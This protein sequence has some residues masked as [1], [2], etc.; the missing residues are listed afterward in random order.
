MSPTPTDAPRGRWPAWLQPLAGQRAN[1]DPSDALTEADPFVRLW[2]GF[3]TARVMIGLTVLLLLLLAWLGG[4]PWAPP[5]WLATLAVGYAA[6]A[7][8]VRLRGRPTR[9]GR[10]FDPQWVLTIGVDVAVFAL[11][12]WGYTRGA[13][14]F[15]P[16]FVLP[17]LTAAVLGSRTLALGTAAAV[18]LLLLAEVGKSWLLLD[19]PPSANDM[20]QAALTGGGLLLVALLANQLSSRLL[21]AQ[22]AALRSRGEAEVQ[23]L[24]NQR[25]IAAMSDGVL[26]LDAQMNLRS[27]N[28]AARA[29]LGTAPDAP[30]PRSLHELAAWRPLVDLALLS[31][32]RGD[33]PAADA[34]LR[35]GPRQ[36]THLVVRTARTPV[37][38]APQRSLCVMFLQDVRET[39]ARMRTEKM[40]AMGRMSAAVAHEIR[41]P[42]A[43]IAQANA[44]LDED[45]GDDSPHFKR[46]TAMVRQNAERLGQIVDDVLDVARVG[47]P[48]LADSPPLALN[49][50]VQQTA[51]E[52]R[53]QHSAGARLALHLRARPEAQARFEAPHLR[54]IL[55]NLLDNAARYASTAAGA[56][57]VAT[58]G[59]GGTPLLLTVWSD[60]APIDAGVERHLFEPFFS[61][62]SRSSG[63]GLYICRELCERHGAVIAYER[64]ARAHAGQPV[65]GN[66]FFISFRA[67]E[68]VTPPA[69]ALP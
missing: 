51:E 14:S 21:R 63:L 56:I 1:P 8:A 40:A 41:N 48:G 64:T 17:V 19:T 9:P 37:P 26:V 29:L 52:W 36:Q 30:P 65:E 62:E 57:Q 42:L 23:T 31:F 50:A 6:L 18:T 55:V 54:R 68:P 53:T 58:Q 38:D 20:A 3:M 27:V 32:A 35:H 22:Q 7:L 45:L 15:L 69:V 16:L 10:T 43:A 34:V 33:L 12:Q 60:G 47:A 44:L 66:E 2:Q 4:P 13:L 39:E 28:P 49:A 5:P 25:I 59:G 46:L 11:L 61:S 24:V 67:A